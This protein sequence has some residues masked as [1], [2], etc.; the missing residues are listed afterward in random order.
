MFFKNVCVWEVAGFEERVS[1]L[2]QGKVLLRTCG[3]GR[4][5]GKLLVRMWDWEGRVGLGGSTAR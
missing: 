4:E 1:G 3:S 2:K 5:Q